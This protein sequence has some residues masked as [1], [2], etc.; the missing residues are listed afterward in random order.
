MVTGSIKTGISKRKREV[1]GLLYKTLMSSEQSHPYNSHNF[2]SRKT[3]S[4]WNRCWKGQCLSQWGD[5]G[6]VESLP[7]KWGCVYSVYW[8]TKKAL[9]EH[10]PK[11]L[12]PDGAFKSGNSSLS[13]ALNLRWSTLQCINP[14][15]R[16]NEVLKHLYNFLELELACTV[17]IGP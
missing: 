6:E 8:S 10:L 5:K 2:P 7:D 17:L 1:S 13:V 11:L 15:L 12:H 3:K 4:S 16:W 14:L 9:S